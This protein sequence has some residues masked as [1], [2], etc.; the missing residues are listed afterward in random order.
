[1]MGN[2]KTHKVADDTATTA[3]GTDTAVTTSPQPK[4]GKRKT[5]E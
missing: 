1:M 3:A 2:L 4:K 5:K